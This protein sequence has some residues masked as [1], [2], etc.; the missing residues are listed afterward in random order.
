MKTRIIKSPD[1]IANDP[2]VITA[3]D[4]LE[5]REELDVLLQKK[6]EAQSYYD[7]CHAEFKAVEKQLIE[8]I[9]KENPV[10]VIIV[11]KES[12]RLHNSGMGYYERIAIDQIIGKS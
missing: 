8:K 3:R 4:F 9:K 1:Q 10:G 11:G 2:I 6:L 5:I 12:I 7:I